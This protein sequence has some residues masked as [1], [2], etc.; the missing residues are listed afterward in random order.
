MYIWGGVSSALDITTIARP[1]QL[2]V[3]GKQ[4]MKLFSPIIF[5]QYKK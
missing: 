1:C 4:A 2:C 5:Y 3:Q